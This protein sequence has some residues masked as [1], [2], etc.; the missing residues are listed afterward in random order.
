MEVWNK[1]RLPRLNAPMCKRA[2]IRSTTSPTKA[3]RDILQYN[4]YNPTKYMIAGLDAEDQI[5]EMYMKET[6]NTV[7]TCGFSIVSRESPYLGATPDGIIGGDGCLQ[8]RKPGFYAPAAPTS[9]ERNPW[10]RLV[11]CHPDFAW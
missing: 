10:L 1:H 6:G 4:D 11:T 8:P 3:M 9:L 5:I 2:D 7:Q